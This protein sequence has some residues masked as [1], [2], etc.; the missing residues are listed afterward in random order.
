MQVSNCCGVSIYENTDVC[1]KCKEHCEPVE[2]TEYYEGL[3]WLELG[4]NPTNIQHYTN[5]D[6]I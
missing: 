1:S 3:E 2:E 4:W 5:K 6:K